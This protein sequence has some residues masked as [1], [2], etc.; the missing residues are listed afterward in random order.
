M[1]N[2]IVRTFLDWNWNI[3][4]YTLPIFFLLIILVTFLKYVI[5]KHGILTYQIHLQCSLIDLTVLQLL[6]HSD[7]FRY[8]ISSNNRK[9]DWSRL[10]TMVG[11]LLILEVLWASW[12]RNEESLLWAIDIAWTLSDACRFTMNI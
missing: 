11:N 5:L 7:P 10:L 12:W 8:Y 2:I 1:R 9:N 6:E 3:E 4:F